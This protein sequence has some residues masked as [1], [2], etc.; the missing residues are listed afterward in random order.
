VIEQRWASRTGVAVGLIFAAPV[1][2]GV[3]FV[4]FVQT[5][6]GHV[7]DPWNISG[8]AIALWLAGLEVVLA[9]IDLI[10]RATE[11]AVAVIIAGWLECFGFATV[12]LWAGLCIPAAP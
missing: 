7:L 11:L 12:I 9:F 10:K 8:P 1:I 4:W 6:V 2:L 3:W 5:P